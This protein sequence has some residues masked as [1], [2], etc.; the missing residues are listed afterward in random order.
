MCFISYC[1]WFCCWAGQQQNREAY[2]TKETREGGKDEIQ[3][4]QRQESEEKRDESSGHHAIS[5]GKHVG[6]S[7]QERNLSP[8]SQDTRGKSGLPSS[9][10]E[11]NWQFI[12]L[13]APLWNSELT[14]VQMDGS[15]DRR[16]LKPVL[17]LE[18]HPPSAITVIVSILKFL[19]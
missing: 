3:P 11:R 12:T 16:E 10:S 4:S 6:R 2:T 15:L 18:Q 7:T 9:P 5:K 14:A 19:L 17:M 1:A 8:P 13:H